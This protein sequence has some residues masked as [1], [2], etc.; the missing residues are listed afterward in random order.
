MI[1]VLQNDVNFGEFMTF[2]VICPVVSLFECNVLVNT[3]T[4]LVMSRRPVYTHA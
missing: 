1:K 4:C 2:L 3:L